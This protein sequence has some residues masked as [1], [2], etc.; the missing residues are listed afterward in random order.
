M[1]DYQGG[2][3]RTWCSQRCRRAAYEERRAAAN[4]AIAVKLVERIESRHELDECVAAVVGSST[5]CWRVLDALA[6][7]AARGEI[8]SDPRW[9][10]TLRALVRLLDALA[11][12]RGL[13]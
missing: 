6:D 5:A 12:A 2:R 9:E 11:P 10:P 4:G 7:A 1:P 8:T 13:R 3:P